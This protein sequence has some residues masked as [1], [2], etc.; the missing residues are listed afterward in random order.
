MRN[1][2]PCFLLV[3]LSLGIS[4]SDKATEIANIKEIKAPLIAL[5]FETVDLQDMKDFQSVAENWKIAG[6]VYVDRSQNRIL[7]LNSG[8]GVLV[9]LPGDGLNDNLYTSFEHGDIELEVDVMMPKNSNS[10]LYFQGRYE[11]QLFDSWGVND[12]KYSDMGGIYE[13]WDDTREGDESGYEGHPPGINAAKAPGLWQHF[14]ILFHAPRFD[15]AGTKIKNATFKEVWL[16]GV[17]IH[18]NFEVTGP[19]RA[20]PF[21]DEVP[22]A[23]LMIQGDHGPVALR[24]IRYK[25]YNDNRVSF[26]KIHIEE[27]ESLAK[28]LPNLDT[29]APV[30]V[31]I[32]DSVSSNMVTERFSQK[33][34]KYTGKLEIP[35]SGDYNFE[36]KVNGGALLMVA[37]DTVI[38][39]DGE[40]D[41]DNPG[42]G[43]VPL[44]K[45]DI[46]FVLI[47]NKHTPWMRGFSVFVEGPGIEK[48]PLHTAAS[49]NLNRGLP[50]EPVF[51]DVF[52]EP[53]T[54]RCFILHKGSKRSHSIAVGMPEG[55]NYAYDLAIG[56]LLQVWNGSFLDA[57]QMWHS[58][59]TH[60]LGEPRGFIV[61]LHGDPD[62]AFLAKENT[63]WPD[64]IPGDTNYRQLGYSFDQV[65][66][67]TF[68]HQ[69]NSTIITNT[70]NPSSSER[71][72]KRTITSNGVNE[73][74]HKIADGS[75]IKI[76]P[77]GTYIV[78]DE[79]Y[80]IDYPVNE[81]LKPIIRQVNGNE[82]LLVKIP[83]GEQEI[84]YS[85]VW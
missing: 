48:H 75:S 18:E 79:S 47:Y 85:I 20:S 77:D 28:L 44:Q 39:L 1:Q 30:R 13:R 5:P 14:K 58:R 31:L 33:I 2:I 4:C 51:I 63:V 60:Q 81:K 34:L 56:S 61:S 68:S 16:N 43:S 17:L 12:P 59:G 10:G 78:N 37:N 11:V 64:S 23:P 35:V 9:N 29:V 54:Q 26:E 73:V 57:T 52:D 7:R 46:P 27:F 84:N 24:N 19:T 55:I 40:Y 67:P 62:F 71:R 36:L 69:L 38:N 82:E 6:D 70:L 65:G 15:A 25:L 49:L 66:V 74:W 21:K 50:E 80:F 32:V 42:Y 45:G 83:P 76:I 72:M 53:I 3:V 8:T 41:S 22:M